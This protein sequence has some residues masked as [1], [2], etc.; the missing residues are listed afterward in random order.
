MSITHE[1]IGTAHVP[2]EPPDPKAL[3]SPARRVLGRS[4]AAAWI[5]RGC[6]LRSQP[7]RLPA[8]I[9]RRVVGCRVGGA[10]LDRATCARRDP[11]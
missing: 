4:I 2:S 7:R 3:F 9:D 8:H 6:W 5:A 1:I 10:G 11:P